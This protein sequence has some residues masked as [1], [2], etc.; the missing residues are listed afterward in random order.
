MAFA[1]VLDFDIVGL[2]RSSSLQRF[3][4][5]KAALEGRPLKARIQLR[6]F[7]AVC[8]LVAAGVGYWLSASASSLRPPL[9]APP[10]PWSSPS[11]TSATTGHCAN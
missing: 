8:R 2:E 9:A 6:S 4:V 7:D 5:A 11:S 3:L 1:E 10:R